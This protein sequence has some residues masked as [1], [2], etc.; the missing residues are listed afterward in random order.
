MSL[1]MW[2]VQSNLQVYSKS[3]SEKLLKICNSSSGSVTENS[4]KI[5]QSSTVVVKIKN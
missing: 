5:P 3:A 2:F 1:T 4:F